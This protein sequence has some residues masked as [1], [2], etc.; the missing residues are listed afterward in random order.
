MPSASVTSDQSSATS[1]T[2]GARTSPAYEGLT[3]S[4]LEG[5]AAGADAMTALLTAGLRNAP[6]PLDVGRWAQLTTERAPAD[7]VHAPR[8]RVRS[9]DRAAS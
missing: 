9:A 8:G 6:W 2:R 5:W 1:A 7:L 4:W 3:G